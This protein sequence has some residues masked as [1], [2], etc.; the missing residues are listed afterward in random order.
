MVVGSTEGQLEANEDEHKVALGFVQTY[1]ALPSIA[2][3]V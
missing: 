3:N 1:R 2:A